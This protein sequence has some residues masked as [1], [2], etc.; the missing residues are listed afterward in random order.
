MYIC[1][2]SCY[3][4]KQIFDFISYCCCGYCIYIHICYYCYSKVPT[5]FLV[6]YLITIV[7][8]INQLDLFCTSNQKIKRKRK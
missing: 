8:P 4:R 7:V 6:N 2:Y 3:A 5:I 1:C